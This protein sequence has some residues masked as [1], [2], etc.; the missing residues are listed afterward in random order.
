[1]ERTGWFDVEI[2][3]Y[4]LI[5]AKRFERRNVA[6]DYKFSQISTRIFRFSVTKTPRHVPNMLRLLFVTNVCAFIGVVGSSPIPWCHFSGIN[7]E[8]S[9]RDL[10][11]EEKLEYA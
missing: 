4:S 7:F 3:K 2:P 6:T 9:V 8:N 5:I 10:D 11:L 1:M